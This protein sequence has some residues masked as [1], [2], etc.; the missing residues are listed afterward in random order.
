MPHP[1]VDVVHKVTGYIERVPKPYFEALA[2]V[3]RVAEESDLQSAR[4][5]DEAALHGVP[6]EAPAVEAPAEE[7][8]G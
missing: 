5:V 7:K 4:A 6:D 3:F 1:L 2:H 8:E